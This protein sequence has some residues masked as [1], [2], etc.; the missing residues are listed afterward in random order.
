MNKDCKFCK[1]RFLM[2]KIKNVIEQ[3]PDMGI[4]MYDDPVDNVYKAADKAMVVLKCDCKARK[5]TP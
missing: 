2:V 4:P 1:A 5:E 3:L